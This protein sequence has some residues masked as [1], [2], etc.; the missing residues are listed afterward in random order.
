ML[1]NT[2]TIIKMVTFNSMS[3]KENS[4]K[5]NSNIYS[6]SAENGENEYLT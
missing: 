4:Y 3:G 1:E 2:S 5:V 6:I